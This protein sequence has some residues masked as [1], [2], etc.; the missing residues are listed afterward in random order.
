MYINYVNDQNKNVYVS[1]WLL[2]ITFL[3]IVMILVGGLTR[4]TD[5]GLS[6]TNWD[7]FSGILPPI[8]KSDW[9]N[10]FS[11]Y[12]KI[13]EYKLLNSS[14]TIEEFKVIFWWEYAH[15]LL[16]RLIGIT[17][18]IPLIYFTWKKLLVKNIYFL[19]I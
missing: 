18:L 5:S 12:K 14:M 1:S 15:R 13:P 7:L 3:L 8:N 10:Y 17:F 16:G 6:I 11:L 4:L 19:F 9:E 2:L